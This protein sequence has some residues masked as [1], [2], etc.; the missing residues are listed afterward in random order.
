M[1]EYLKEVIK[2][3]YKWL[4]AKYKKLT[5]NQI[6]G[7]LIGVS[8]LVAVIYFWPIIAATSTSLAT[9]AAASF[10]SSINA[11]GVFFAG[12]SDEA[13]QLV[14]SMAFFVAVLIFDPSLQQPNSINSTRKKPD[15]KSSWTKVKQTLGLTPMPK[16]TVSEMLK[17]L[18]QKVGGYKTILKNLLISVFLNRKNNPNKGFVLYGPPGTGKTTIAEAIA[19]LFSEAEVKIVCGPELLDKWLGN[20]EKNVRGLFTTAISNKKKL[21]IVVINEI[22]ALFS[23]R[24]DPNG[25]GGVTHNS[26]VT[27]MLTMLDDPGLKNILIIGT[28]NHLNSLDPALLRPGRLGLPIYVPLPSEEDRFQILQKKF[29]QTVN[30]YPIDWKKCAEKTEGFSGADIDQLLL[31]AQNKALMAKMEGVGSDADLD[32]LADQDNALVECKI[33]EE[34]V[35]EAVNQI[36]KDKLQGQL[37]PSPQDLNKGIPADM[38]LAWLSKL[39]PLPPEPLVPQAPRLNN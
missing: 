31:T 11:I 15:T 16:K 30:N 14:L 3:A 6:A 28:T 23:K 17:A 36:Q 26:I 39:L 9:Q 21:H 38:L 1:F 32:L 24:T 2:N 13:I 5:F 7:F 35:N 25:P 22:D 34:I 19:E 12:L 33:T 8:I 10:T 4:C 18:E 37:K 27:Q 20:S 29:N